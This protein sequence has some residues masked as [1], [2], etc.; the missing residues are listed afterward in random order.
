LVDILVDN[1][2]IT[3]K[4][5]LIRL[6]LSLLISRL[7]T[8]RFIWLAAGPGHK[9]DCR[10]KPKHQQGKQTQQPGHSGS[11]RI[12][13]TFVR[14]G[15]FCHLLHRWSYGFATRLRYTAS[16]HGFATGFCHTAFAIHLATDFFPNT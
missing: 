14:G 6:L 10:T 7:I 13:R 15:R 16:L 12:I 9:A 4:S 11:R 8:R 2:L 5:P 1:R 3:V